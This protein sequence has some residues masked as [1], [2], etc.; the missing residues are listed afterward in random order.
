P[1]E[2]AIQDEAV[3]VIRQWAATGVTTSTEISLGVSTSMSADWRLF[4]KLAEEPKK[5]LRFRV[6]L[7][8]HQVEPVNPGDPKDQKLQVH[9]DP[10]IVF[11]PDKDDDWLKVLGVKFVTDGSTQGFTAFLNQPYLNLDP[12]VTPPGST[13]ISNFP[14]KTQP[15][16]TEVMR[17]FY[18]RGWQ[19]ATHA[20]GDAAI[21]QVLD[22]YQEI[23]KGDPKRLE[24]R[25]RIEHFTVTPPEHL[26]KILDRV[27]ELGVT[28]GMT[29]GHLYF[30]GQVFDQKILG[31]ERAG[32]IH[33]SKSLTKRHIRFAYN[34][35]SPVTKVEP[36]RYVQTEV[37]REPQW[38][39][40]QN[41]PFVLGADEKISVDEA[42]RAVTLDAAYQ[43]FFDDKV[44]SL[45][46]GKLADFVVLACNPKA[47]EPSTI[48]SI[49]VLA[50]YLAGNIA[51]LSDRKPDSPD[52]CHPIAAAR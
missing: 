28:P 17:P 22:V 41:P 7:D 48:A 19:L 45:E 23:S 29:A 42:L 39:P 1:S 50:T 10:S 51:Y 13:G 47:V 6:Y 26:A 35:D 33:P 25:L 11:E 20:N 34:S 40:P 52:D 43:D 16:L 15:T 27:V 30:W 14:P 12:P 38:T 18:E 8:Y 46:K 24:R 21:D 37:T 5:L 32:K 9:G 36:L 2:K 49:Q 4:R 44:G 3:K 31:T